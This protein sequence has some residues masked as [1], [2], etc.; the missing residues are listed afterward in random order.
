MLR[1]PLSLTMLEFLLSRDIDLDHILELHFSSLHH[2]KM[3]VISIK[4]NNSFQKKLTTSQIVE[5]VATYFA[6]VVLN[7]MQDCFVLNQEITLN[8]ILKQQPEVLFLSIA[9]PDLP[10]T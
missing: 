4:S 10:H 8:L 2:T 1:Q 5:Q 7:A 9:L 3:Q 6:S